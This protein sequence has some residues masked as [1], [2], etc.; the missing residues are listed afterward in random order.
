MDTLEKRITAYLTAKREATL[1]DI[2]Q[3]VKGAA[4]PLGKA[5]IAMHANGALTF[6]RVKRVT[7]WRLA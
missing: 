1:D 3:N 4:Q 2:K 6:S 5:V 7:L